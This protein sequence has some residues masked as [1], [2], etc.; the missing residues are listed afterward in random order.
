M[1]LS[2]FCTENVEN[3]FNVPIPILIEFKQ[4]GG[5]PYLSVITGRGN[6]S[7]GGVARI[8]PAVIKYLT[9]HSFR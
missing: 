1:L 7:Q 6:H 9:S 4:N 8:K 3:Y 5:K 2:R